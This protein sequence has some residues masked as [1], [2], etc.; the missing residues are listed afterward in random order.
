MSV[1]CN[2]IEIWADDSSKLA[3]YFM[4][5]LK[6]VVQM[7]IRLRFVLQ[8]SHVELLSYDISKSH[9]HHVKLKPG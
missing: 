4:T 5:R 2:S 3:G 1:Q 9:A 6:L 7:F 8:E